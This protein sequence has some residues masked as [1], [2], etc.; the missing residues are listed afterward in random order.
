[1]RRVLVLAPVARPLGGGEAVV[2]WTLHALQDVYRVTLLTWEPPD[3]LGMNRIYGTRLDP[4]RFAVFKAPWAVR[5]LLAIDPDPRSIYPLILLWRI[6]RWIGHRYAAVV[7]LHGE[8][9]LGRRGIQYIH[10]PFLAEKIIAAERWRDHAWRA[11]LGRRLAPWL[12]VSGIR[13]EQVC[14]NLTLANSQWTAARFE[15]AYGVRPQVVYPP[16]APPAHGLPWQQRH[17][18]FLCCGRWGEEKRFEVSMEIVATLR[19]MGHD[20]G[21]TI[22]ALPWDADYRRRLLERIAAAGAWIDVHENLDRD[23]FSALVGR[24]RYGLHANPQEH[25]GIA[26]AEMASG[27]CIVFVADDGGQVEII[28]GD[29][30]LL[31]RTPSEAAERIDAV[32][33]D[34]RLQ[35]ELRAR[36]TAHARTFG[37]ERFVAEMRGVV[38]ELIDCSADGP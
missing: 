8:A 1:M 10:Y 22:V 19:R 11:F 16:I 29:R 7:H 9:S 14:A 4:A 6:A 32:L 23:A 30:R 34:A 13:K 2:A 27:G 21:L 24:H 36:L 3:W 28:D 15:A 20:V 26:P 31:W 38:R 35:D 25:F 37:C 5:R 33:Q 17:P 12:L 18:S